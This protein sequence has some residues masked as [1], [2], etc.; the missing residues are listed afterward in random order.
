MATI[1]FLPASPAD[2]EDGL[3]W[4]KIFGHGFQGQAVGLLTTV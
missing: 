1:R 2:G 3:P 4:V